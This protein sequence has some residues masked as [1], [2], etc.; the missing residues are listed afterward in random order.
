V[1]L[2][3]SPFKT[4]RQLFMEKAGLAEQEP[5]GLAAKRGKTLEHIVAELYSILTERQVEVVREKIIHPQMDFIWAQV[6]RKITDAAKKEGILE[7]KCPGVAVFNKAKREG[8]PDYY[9][10][11]LQHY[12]GVTGKLWGAFAVFSAERWELLKFDVERNEKLIQIIFQK[13]KEFW[14]D[15]LAGHVPEE[16][17]IAVELPDVQQGEVVNVDRMQYR[18][19]WAEIIMEYRSADQMYEEG[20]ALLEVSEEKIKAMMESMSAKIAEG[21]G[22]RVY[23][24]EQAGKKTLDK[25]LFLKENPLAYEVYESFLKAGKPS[26]PFRIFFPRKILIE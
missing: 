8:L 12:L 20:K 16:D 22:A 18:Q 25:K 26:R 5:A 9:L 13:D 23:F 21:A 1:I 10:V 14:Q 4:R 2:G 17:Q 24:K 15:V 19:E 6:D 7:I 3:I 11:Q